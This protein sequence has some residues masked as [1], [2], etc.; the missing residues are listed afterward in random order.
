MGLRTLRFECGVLI[1]NVLGC[2]IECSWRGKNG[3]EVRVSD[4]RRGTQILDLLGC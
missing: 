3:S 4:T 1:A 2:K